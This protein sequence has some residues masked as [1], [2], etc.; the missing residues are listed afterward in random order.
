MPQAPPAGKTR[1]CITG[2]GASPHSGRSQLLAD[3]LT[4]KYP[5]QIEYWAWYDTVYFQ[6]Y[7]DGILRD[8]AC[9]SEDDLKK[10]DGHITSPFVWA[11]TSE[12]STGIG[13]GSDFCKWATEKYPEDKEVQALADV[14]PGLTYT[15]FNWG[16]GVYDLQ[17]TQLTDA[18]EKEERKKRYAES[19]KTWGDDTQGGTIPN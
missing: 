13:E 11:V 18:D 8:V 6:R 17:F 15:G 9:L 12:G 14:S 5:D 7:I 16:S 1:I 10:F 2:F 4:K 3:L 19:R